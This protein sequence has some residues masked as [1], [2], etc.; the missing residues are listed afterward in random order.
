MNQMTKVIE[1]FKAIIEE[2]K[3]DLGDAL[4]SADIWHIKDAQSLG[5]FNVAPKATALF[6]EVTRMLEKT[7]A[8]SEFPDLGD[9]YMVHT[10]NGYLVIINKADDYQLGMTVDLS[11]TTMGILMSIVLPKIQESLK[12]AIK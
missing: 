4:V 12:N 1:I 8:S 6:N 5:G 3:S 11:K 2:L 7:L 9:Y 10:A